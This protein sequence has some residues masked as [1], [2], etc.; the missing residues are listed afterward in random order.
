[1]NNQYPNERSN[2]DNIQKVIDASDIVQIIGEYIPLERKGNDY[3]GLCP[4]HNDSNPSLSVSPSKKVFKCFSCNTAG[5]V[6]QFVQKIENISFLEALKKVAAKSGITLDIKENPKEVRNQ[7]YY[8]IMAQASEIY[9]FYLKNTIEGKGA[10]E[11]LKKRNLTEDIIKRFQIGLSSHNDN[12]IVKTLV[13]NNRYLPLDLQEIGLIGYN[14]NRYFDLFNSRIMFP[15][16]DLKGNVVGFSGRIYDTTSNSKYINSQENIIFKKSNI[17]YNYSDAFNEIKL[18]G[19]VIIFEGF[20]DVIAAYRAGVY[21]TIAT[22]GTALTEEQIKVILKLTNDI[23][24]CYDGDGPGIEASRRAIKLFAKY[25]VNVKMVMLPNDMDPDDY[26]NSFGAEKTKELLVNQNLSSIDYLY[27]IEKNKL[28]LNDSNSIALFQKNVF[29]LIKFFDSAALKQYLLNVLSKDLNVNLEEITSEFSKYKSFNSQ[30]NNKKSNADYID[31][32]NADIPIYD[33][34]DIPVYEPVD[35]VPNDYNYPDFNPDDYQ[36]IDYNNFKPKKITKAKYQN[37]E[38]GIIYLSFCHKE[39]CKKIQN[40]LG[41]DEFVDKV[42]RNILYQLYDYYSLADQ[43]NRD[44]FES[45]LSDLEIDRLNAIINTIDI[46]MRESID[47][48]ISIVKNYKY[49]KSKGDISDDFSNGKGN[50][51]KL[52]LYVTYKRKGLKIN[53]NNEK[54]EQ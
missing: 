29:E 23:R 39:D 7:K 10:L 24:L 9:Q 21:N 15:L 47:D 34:S 38:E 45:K 54:K 6:I 20:M 51:D 53:K 48:Y 26:I 42:N 46:F 35:Y 33:Y 8:Q 13:D 40:K 11:Y 18:K 44:E 17:L 1:M 22:M 12:I 37:A 2:S 3:K 32:N 41:A 27:N 25:G 43:M 16:K 52:Q 19:F 50:V 28:N 5:N 31:Y 4:F 36:K 14:N 30:T 49:E